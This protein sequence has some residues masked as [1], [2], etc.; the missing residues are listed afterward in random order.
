MAMSR[1]FGG[2]WFTSLFPIRIS[3]PVAS[4]RPAIM[5][6][7]VDLPQPDGPTMTRNSRLS[8][9]RFASLTATTPPGYVFETLRRGTRAITRSCGQHRE[10]LRQGRLHVPAVDDEV[11]QAV[12]QQELRALEPFRQLLPD[13]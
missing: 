1:S 4:S 12:L 9:L 5:R 2:T 3:P 6:R 8:T 10:E 13:G 7:R 11:D